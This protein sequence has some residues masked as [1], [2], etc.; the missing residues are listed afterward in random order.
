MFCI[1]NY[2]GFPNVNVSFHG[3]IYSESDFALFTNQWKQLYEDKRY[4]TFVF[5]MKDIG[6][7]NPYW[8]YRVASFISELKKEPIQYLT[9]STIINVNT[10]TSYLLQIVFS[11]QSPVAPV[12]IQLNKGDDIYITP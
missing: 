7:I 4:F 6:L 9:E 5:D 2:Q 12:T 10:F 8:S 3:S 11:F 1:Y